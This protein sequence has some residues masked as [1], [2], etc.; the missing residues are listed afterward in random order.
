MQKRKRVRTVLYDDQQLL[1]GE[2]DLLHTPSFQRLYDLHQL[3]LSDRVYIDASHARIHHV[4]GVLRQVDRLVCSISTNLRREPGRVLKYGTRPPFHDLTCAQLA[5]HVEDHRPVVR[6]IGLLHDLTQAPYG[7]TIE[8]EIQLIGCKH[9]NPDRQAKAFYRL[10][11]E[12]IGWLG[13]DAG[14]PCE[15]VPAQPNRDDAGTLIP[16]E[17]RRFL[18]RP[19]TEPPMSWEPIAKLA[20]ALLRTG[21]RQQGR[22][23]WPTTGVQVAGLFAEVG[24]AMTAL[25]H[26]ELL[27]SECGEKVDVPTLNEYSFQKLIRTT[28]RDSGHGHLLERYKFEPHRDAYMLDIVGNTVCADL[29]DYARRDA[30]FANLKLDYDADRIAENFTLVSHRS[31]AS[32]GSS[33]SHVSGDLAGQARGGQRAFLGFCLRT[34]VSLF[35]HKLRIDVPGELMNL[36][37]VRFYL[38]ERV[39][40]HST[41]CAAG[42]MLGT[43]VQLLGWRHTED[44]PEDDEILPQRL[45]HVGDAVFLHEVHQAGLL[46]QETLVSAQVA[47]ARSVASALCEELSQAPSC[48]QRELAADLVRRHCDRPI[49]DALRDVRAGL[50][51]L[52][53]LRARRFVRPVVRALSNI[54]KEQFDHEKSP[55]LAD[56]FQRPRLRY[57]AERR[58]EE[59]ASLPRGS[60]VIHC[61]RWMPSR[62][63]A[64]VLLTLPTESGGEPKVAKLREIKTI[65]PELFGDHQ[66]AIVAVERMYAS[67]WRLVV[68]VAPDHLYNWKPV[69]NVAVDVINEILAE[70]LNCEPADVSGKWSPD[71]HL[72]RELEGRLAAEVAPMAG[73][74]AIEHPRDGRLRVALAS[75]DLGRALEEVVS[76]GH[77]PLVGSLLGEPGSALYRQDTAPEVKELKT[78]ILQSLGARGF[79]RL[80]AGADRMSLLVDAVRPLWGVRM[81][82]QPEAEIRQWGEVKLR[83]TPDGVFSG[84]LQR[85]EQGVSGTL[86]LPSGFNRPG[87]GSKKKGSDDR[88]TTSDVI[89]FLDAMI[90]GPTAEE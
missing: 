50:D 65:D 19:E 68:Y 38:Y 76:E 18:D 29:L 9:D 70:H 44:Q 57:V 90:E 56:A 6:L 22:A 13:V 74:V 67:M 30:H 33:P 15:R 80:P 83:L 5:D 47:G 2:L 72:E 82:R 58:I 1:P 86:T 64:N 75:V 39:I 48:P 71:A 77:M 59:R 61:P 88:M 27:H 7:H 81:G 79:R 25:L 26:L 3:G 32:D 42:A 63:L 52:V 17:L 20:A 85:V 36:L 40:Y 23:A 69:M 10:L 51:L 12:Y 35:S 84:F 62:K 55:E 34:A 60:V 28:L 45:A 53:R 4:V 11:C 21:D 43:A 8:D 78:A 14:V 73:T 46:A 41:K 54:T 49:S 24:M 31:S 37:N 66:S 16:I 87:R 89:R